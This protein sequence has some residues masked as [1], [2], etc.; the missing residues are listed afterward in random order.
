MQKYLS[1]ITME[2]RFH[3]LHLAIIIIIHISQLF[4]YFSLF[5]YS[6]FENNYFFLFCI[7]FFFRFFVKFV[8]IIMLTYFVIVPSLRPSAICWKL[9][10]LLAAA[11]WE[12]TQLDIER[13]RE[14]AQ[15]KLSALGAR[16]S[17]VSVRDTQKRSSI[18]IK[19]QE[20]HKERM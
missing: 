15:L 10:I 2:Y 8:W 20:E 1:I 12:C 16:S 13:T 18:M 17:S 7:R 9:H 5:V 6:I 11:P 3:F 14:C 19:R 4:V